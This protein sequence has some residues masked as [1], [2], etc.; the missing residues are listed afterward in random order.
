MTWQ[1][2]VLV[3]AM[4]AVLGVLGWG[5][6]SMGRGGGYNTYWSNRIMRLRVALQ[7]IAI[8]IFVLIVLASRG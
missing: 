7:A 1:Y 5:I 3:V 2:I 6:V 8:V 4:L